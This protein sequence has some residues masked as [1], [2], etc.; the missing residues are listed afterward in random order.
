MVTAMN[1]PEELHVRIG[2]LRDEARGAGTATPGR[3]QVDIVDGAI[4][5][6]AQLSATGTKDDERRQ[7]LSGVQVGATVTSR[8][9]EKTR[10]SR[11]EKM[12]KT[13]A[14]AETLTPDQREKFIVSEEF[15]ALTDR[16]A[17][18]ISAAFDRLAER[19][20]EDSLGVENIDLENVPD[21]DAIV[22]NEDEYSEPI[23]AA[24][25]DESDYE[26]LFNQAGW[27]KGEQS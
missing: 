10:L 20:L 25:L 5:V 6:A 1:K 7:A 12:D 17:E 21:V 4:R 15:D 2:R 14:W 26:E 27:D 3:E 9:V 8:G 18:G 19:E 11:A 23:D 24:E 16:Q 22:G 13:L